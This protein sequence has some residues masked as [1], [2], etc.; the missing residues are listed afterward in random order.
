MRKKLILTVLLSFGIVLSCNSHSVMA[1][2]PRDVVE[3]YIKALIHKNNMLAQSYLHSVDTMPEIKLSTPIEEF[4]VVNTPLKDTKV[5][6]AFFKGEVG[7]ERIAFIWELTVRDEKISRIKIIHDGTNPFLEEAKLVKEY[8]MKYQR[9][10]LV[11]TKFPFEITGIEGY[12]H[13]QRLLLRYRSEPIN[14]FLQFTVS[15][16]SVE[17]E[18]Y[19]GK[20]DEYHILKNGTKVL[21][22]TKFDLG[23]E[24]RFQKDGL[25]YTVVIGNKKFLKKKF[26]LDDLIQIAES[27]N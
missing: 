7:G 14:G 24:I 1:E 8:E 25:H 16:V 3:K 19:K 15:P 20:Y 22:R 6:V 26:T 23:Y 5:V 4:K 10:L 2:S 13:N 12:I 17:L 27:M 18:R 11:P 9:N 21:Y